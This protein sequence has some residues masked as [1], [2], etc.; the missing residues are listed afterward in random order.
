[1]EKSENR[2]K[3]AVKEAAVMVEA[4][5]TKKESVDWLVRFAVLIVVL[6]EADWAI[7]LDATKAARNAAIR[8]L[9]HIGASIRRRVLRPD[10]E[11]ETHHKA[12]QEE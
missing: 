3:L 4:L 6:V 7:A 5:P 10:V 12:Q 8:S 11:E 1:V 9:A 2:E